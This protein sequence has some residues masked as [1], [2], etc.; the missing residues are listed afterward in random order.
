MTDPTHLASEDR[1]I[2]IP[3]MSCLGEKLH[4]YLNDYSDMWIS[5][6]EED[7]APSA[8]FSRDQQLRLRDWLNK[9]LA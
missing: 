3:S 5:F 4:F 8:C 6:E 1:R 9:V 2:T 7:R